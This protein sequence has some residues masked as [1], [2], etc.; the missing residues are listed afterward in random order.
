MWLALQAL[1]LAERFVYLAAFTAR[2]TAV[3]L[4]RVGYARARGLVH[5]PC[6]TRSAQPPSSS[7]RT[8]L[9]TSSVSDFR[10]C[11]TCAESCGA[12]TPSRTFTE[13]YR[14]VP[15]DADG[16]DLPHDRFRGRAFHAELGHEGAAVE[17][18]G[19]RLRGGHGH[20]SHSSHA[21]SGTWSSLCFSQRGSSPPETRIVVVAGSPQI[22]HRFPHTA[23][24]VTPS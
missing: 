2:E 17:E 18:A 14:P 3:R 7:I 9:Y 19:E 15:V 8:W 22:Q 23:A 16:R 1:R 10:V 20:L 11:P 4:E 13:M 6:L 24:A 21:Q 12:G 5:H